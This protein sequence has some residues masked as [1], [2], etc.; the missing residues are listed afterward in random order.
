VYGTKIERIRSRSPETGGAGL[1]LA[2][3]KK[4]VE[5]HGG[6]IEVESQPGAGSTFR[7]LLPAAQPAKQPAP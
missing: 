7:V 3:T 1:G 5:Q 4:I 6:Q 2:I